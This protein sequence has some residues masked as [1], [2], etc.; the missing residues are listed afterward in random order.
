MTGK[1]GHDA[2]EG[3]PIPTIQRSTALVM[4]L[5]GSQEFSGNVLNVHSGNTNL[6][7]RSKQQRRQACQTSMTTI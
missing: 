1:E 3:N 4:V 5:Q 7:V 2:E 6:K